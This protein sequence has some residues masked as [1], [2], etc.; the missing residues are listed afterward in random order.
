[1]PALPEQVRGDLAVT[2]GLRGDRKPGWTIRCPISGQ[3]GIEPLVVISYDHEEPHKR[4]SWTSRQ[5]PHGRRF[6]LCRL[7]PGAGH[8]RPGRCRP[9]IRCRFRRRRCIHAAMWTRPR[10]ALTCDNTHS[11]AS[12]QGSL[13]ET[14]AA[15]LVARYGEGLFV[16]AARWSAW[17]AGHD[18]AVM[19]CLSG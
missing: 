6:S 10:R 4:R 9:A 8:S 14:L 17:P 3:R 15:L 12:L 11:R 2:E 7:W 16:P 19:R 1:M 5:T 13:P 18:H